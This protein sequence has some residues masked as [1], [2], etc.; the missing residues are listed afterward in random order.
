MTSMVRCGLFFNWETVLLVILK[1]LCFTGL[2]GYKQTFYNSFILYKG[3]EDT[4]AGYS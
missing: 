3:I 1:R 2:Y 4:I